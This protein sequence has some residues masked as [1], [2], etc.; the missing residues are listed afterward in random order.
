MPYDYQLV[1]G[2]LIVM[3]GLV[4]MTNAMVEKRTPIFGLVGIL[5]GA[6]LLGWAWVLSDGTLTSYHLPQ[7]VFRLIAAWK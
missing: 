4:G 1:S 3:I 2:T 7:A 5:A 6:G